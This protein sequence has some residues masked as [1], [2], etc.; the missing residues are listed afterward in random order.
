[1]RRSSARRTSTAPASFPTWRSDTWADPGHQPKPAEWKDL[2]GREL[3]R[4][5]HDWTRDVIAALDRQVTPPEMVQVGN[6][7]TD[8]FL[9]DDGRLSGR[10]P[11]AEARWDRLAGLL[12]ADLGAVNE[13]RKGEKPIRLMIHIDRGGDNAACRRFF[14]NLRRRDVAFDVIGLSYYPWWQGA[15]DKLGPNLNDLS[16]RY[17]KDLI[18]VE[19]AYPCSP[20]GVDPRWTTGVKLDPTPQGQATYLAALTRIVRNTPDGRGKGVYY[21]EPAWLTTPKAGSQWFERGLFD[22]NGN[23]LGSIRGL[24]EN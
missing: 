17:G 9:W 6:E 19:T 11:G 16:S 8:G 14:D 20:R 5:V 13:G 18:V 4:A 10:D 7:I 2:H 12:K 24:G 21:W 15:I 3:E 23:L 1:M 22:A